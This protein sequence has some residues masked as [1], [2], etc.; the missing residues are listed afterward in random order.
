MS[1]LFSYTHKISKRARGV[2]LAVHGDG[3]VVVTSPK[4]V[5]KRMVE[6]F[7]I[8]KS[9]WIL[10]K[11][12]IITARPK[13]MLDTR[14]AQEYAMY[15]EQARELVVRRLEHFNV[16]Y[17][18]TYKRVS[19]RNQKTRWGSCSK[20]GNLSFH[21]KIA[22]L[23]ERLADYIIVHELCHLKEMNH[24]KKFW[25]LVAYTLPDHKERRLELRAM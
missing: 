2:K 25:A 13:K 21:Y 4:W 10:D 12:R 19:I 20:Q 17:K 16:F 8:K 1:K 6:K 7:V 14:S 9:D 15:K 22:L 11:L 24:S 23:P 3:S 18:Y 5:G